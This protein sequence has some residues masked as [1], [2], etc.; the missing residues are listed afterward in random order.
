MEPRMYSCPPKHIYTGQVIREESPDG[1]VFWRGPVWEGSYTFGAPYLAPLP[2]DEVPPFPPQNEG[3]SH[4]GAR[5]FTA[6][7]AGCHRLSAEHSAGPHLAGVVGRRAGS[8]AGFEASAA[9]SGLDVVWTRE[10]LAEFIENPTQFAPGTTM[11]AVGVTPEEA[12]TI[13]EFL[14]LER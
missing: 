12:R 5:L 8:V 10:N 13:A 4:P 6:F 3:T 2:A 7:C 9:V 14:E 11:T 1:E